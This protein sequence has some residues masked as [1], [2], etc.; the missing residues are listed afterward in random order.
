MAFKSVKIAK[1][2]CLFIRQVRVLLAIL[3][4]LPRNVYSKV[5]IIKPG[6]SRLQEFEKRIVLDV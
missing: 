1:R 5:S 6:R 4:V 2:A 3:L